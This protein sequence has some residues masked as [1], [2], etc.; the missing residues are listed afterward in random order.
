MQQHLE[1]AIQESP[2]RDM[3]P[4]I[5]L[6]SGSVFKAKSGIFMK[7]MNPEIPRLA[8]VSDYPIWAAD[9]GN[10]HINKFDP[11]E[12]VEFVGPCYDKEESMQRHLEKAIQEIDEAIWTVQDMTGDQTPW[13]ENPDGTIHEANILLGVCYGIL[14]ELIDGRIFLAPDKSDEIGQEVIL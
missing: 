3:G 4:V 1:K 9:V 2:V 8:K 10:G 12:Q 11:S 14:R 13:V 6:Q 5:N 7:L